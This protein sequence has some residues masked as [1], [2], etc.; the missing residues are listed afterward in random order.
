MRCAPRMQRIRFWGGEDRERGHQFIIP[1]RVP[2][3]K[4]RVLPAVLVVTHSNTLPSGHSRGMLSAK[5]QGRR[6][7][8]VHGERPESYTGAEEGGT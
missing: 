1:Q 4:E 3:G 6:V 7:R 8:T 2:H 5:S